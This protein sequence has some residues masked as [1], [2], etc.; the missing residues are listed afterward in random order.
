MALR[1]STAEVLARLVQ[2]KPEWSFDIYAGSNPA[3]RSLVYRHDGAGPGDYPQ[4]VITPVTLS[5]AD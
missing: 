3:T 5:V 1:F 4:S 2:R